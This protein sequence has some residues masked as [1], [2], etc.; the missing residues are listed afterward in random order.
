MLPVKR[1]AEAAEYI[2]TYARPLDRAMYLY[3]FEDEPRDQVLY[4]LKQFQ[5][6]DGGFGHGLE[7]DFRVPNSTP[8]ATT[9]AFQ[10]MSRLGVSVAEPMVQQGI[11]YFLETMDRSRYGWQATCP[12]VND[13]PH[14]WWWHIEKKGPKVIKESAWVNP[15]A[16]ITGYFHQ[17]HALVSDDMLKRTCDQLMGHFRRLVTMERIRSKQGK[18]EGV[19]MHDF[20]CYNRALP[21]LPLTER[22]E[23][24]EHMPGL[25]AASLETDPSRWTGYSFDPSWFITKPT[26]PFADSYRDEIPTMLEWLVDTQQAD[27]SWHPAWTWNQYEADWDVAKVEWQ[28]KLTVNR[29]DILKNFHYMEQN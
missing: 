25:L 5:N 12:E 21:F 18:A 4:E 16:E 7:P 28:G 3:L 24:M 9:E 26:Q 1:Q 14:A 15:S 29:L 27:G 13:Y 19:E 6:A 10:Y 8:L 17:F 22:E 2:L 11:E 23:I 20:L